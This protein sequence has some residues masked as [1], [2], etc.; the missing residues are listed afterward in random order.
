MA[1]ALPL[2]GNGVTPRRARHNRNRLNLDTTII[3]IVRTLDTLRQATLTA[4]DRGSL[5][6]P[7]KLSP[8]TH[9][10]PYADGFPFLSLCCT[11]MAFPSRCEI[12][13]KRMLRRCHEH[14]EWVGG[15]NDSCPKCVT[16][17]VTERVQTVT[18]PVTKPQPVTNP[19]TKHCP[20]CSCGKVYGSNAER[21]KAYRGRRG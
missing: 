21:Q 13:E 14:G 4:P 17:P 15:L 2:P 8:S 20:T 1:R 10:G 6:T 7:A 12:G 19:V 18:Q 16:Q 3:V 5:P 11:D 9:P